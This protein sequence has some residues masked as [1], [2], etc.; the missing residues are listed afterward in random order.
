[1]NLDPEQGE[2]ELKGSPNNTPVQNPVSDEDEE[3]LEKCRAFY[4]MKLEF[5]ERFH[6][7]PCK[8]SLY[9]L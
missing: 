1:M 6:L 7:H 4:E 3:F 5:K 2:K 9:V 8:R